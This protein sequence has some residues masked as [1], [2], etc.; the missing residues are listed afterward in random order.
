MLIQN[1]YIIVYSSDCMTDIENGREENGHHFFSTIWGSESFLMVSSS[2]NFFT[3][4][5]WR[6]S[7]SWERKKRS[8]ID[9]M[10]VSGYAF[11]F[12]FISLPSFPVVSVSLLLPLD[13]NPPIQ[14]PPLGSQTAAF[15][16]CEKGKWRKTHRLIIN[17]KGC[18]YT[19]RN[20]LN[21]PCS[22]CRFSP[23]ETDHRETDPCLSAPDVKASHVLDPFRTWSSNLALGSALK[24]IHTRYGPNFA[25][26]FSRING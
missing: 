9:Q 2:T 19:S 10:T 11:I 26:N 15:K 4:L 23:C 1:K 20:Q 25:V 14:P 16:K 12:P 6:G 7:G 18:K 5:L 8:K 24:E 22:G 3:K 13:S 21:S 17:T